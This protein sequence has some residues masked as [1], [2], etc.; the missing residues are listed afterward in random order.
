MREAFVA[1]YRTTAEGAEENQRLVE[2]VYAELA[3]SRPEGLQYATFRLDDGVTFVHVAVGGEGVLPE[4]PAF[5]EFQRELGA[6]LDGR[7]LE[8][9]NARLVGRYQS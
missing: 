1:R 9:S 2:A 5:Q 8:G 7:P 3:Q 4:L 6:R